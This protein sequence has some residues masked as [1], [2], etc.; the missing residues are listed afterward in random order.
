VV[1]Y[2]HISLSKKIYHH[3][4]SY[5]LNNRILYFRSMEKIR[6]YITFIHKYSTGAM[7]L[8]IYLAGLGFSTLSTLPSSLSSHQHKKATHCTSKFCICSH[9]TGQ[10]SCDLATA[11]ETDTECKYKKCATPISDNYTGGS[12]STFIVERQQYFAAFLSADYISKRLVDLSS[13][14]MADPPL[15]PPQLV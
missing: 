9:Y 12:I 13:Q 3:K 14:F 15:H 10:C 5:S 11:S 7:L 2:P 6:T 1:K 4:A 8:L